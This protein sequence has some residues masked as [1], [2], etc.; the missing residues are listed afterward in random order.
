MPG[1][2]A[3][4]AAAARLGAPLG[5]DFCAISLSDNLKPWAVL[6]TRLRA[7]AQAGFVIALYNAR[8]LA[9]PDLLGRAF[10]VLS[11]ILPGSTV[12]AFAR[13]VSTE[14]ERI[15]IT[16]LADADPSLVDMRTLVLIGTAAT[17]LIAR[18]GAAP[19]VYSPR[20]VEASA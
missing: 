20:F 2:S 6:E 13:A 11:E 9:R 14:A 18:E 12:V 16:N 17:R 7:V 1:I 3:M 8:S 15:H 19:F 5:A 10:A 4:F